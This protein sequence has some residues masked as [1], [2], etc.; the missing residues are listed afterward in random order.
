MPSSE[1]FV[2]VFEPAGLP[3]P[4]V[5]LLLLHGTGGDER[6]LLPLGHA[7]LP[8]AAIL[9]PRG[10]VLERGM[11]RFFRRLA[12]GVFDQEDLAIQTTE[13]ALFVRSAEKEH[14]LMPGHLV[15]VGFSNG[16]N[17]ASSLLMTEPEVLAG[18]VLMRGMP[19]FVPARPWTLNYK[20][21]L[22][23][24]GNND[25]IVGRDQAN[26]LANLFRKAGANLTVHWSEAGHN[27]SEDDLHVAKDWLAS[28][29]LT[30]EPGQARRA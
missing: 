6:D 20:P 21:V 14:S 12:E 2:Y 10:R 30:G 28:A 27:L 8:G 29:F 7:L 17:I 15:A 16:A 5:G 11:P 23:L 3:A 22:I 25:P 13:L 18:A 9:S 24:S 4:P 26:Q 1:Q 19:P